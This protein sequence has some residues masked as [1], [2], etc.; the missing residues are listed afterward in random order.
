[1]PCA[2]YRESPPRADLADVVNCVWTFEGNDAAADQPVV[3]DG[4]CELIVHCAEPY[5]E[6]LPNSVVPSVQSSVLFAGQVTRPLTL[7]ASG[8]VSVVA[9]RFNPCGA[10]RFLARSLAGFTDRRVDLGSLLGE[11]AQALHGRIVAAPQSQRTV[12]AQD[13]V[14]SRIAAARQLPDILV[15]LCVALIYEDRFAALDA[16]RCQASLSARTLQ[17]RFA[18]VVGVSPRMLSA[19]VRFRRVFDALHQSEASNWTEAAH[20]AG[21]YDLSQLDRDFRRFT[22]RPPSAFLKAGPGLATSLVKL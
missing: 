10:W 2:E 20:A 6:Y 1:L 8:P 7:R 16:E 19:I 17:R 13:F 9:V 15:E 18:T 21:Y 3:P 5:R 12:I 4:R 14:S 11:S 22:G